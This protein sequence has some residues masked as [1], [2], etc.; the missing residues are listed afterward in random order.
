M[1]DEGQG[2]EGAGSFHSR[3]RQMGKGGEGEI[4]RI[5]TKCAHFSL[6]TSS[7]LKNLTNL[8]IARGSASKSS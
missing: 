7:S 3:F 8:A 2:S 4:E 5:L 1:T 6:Y